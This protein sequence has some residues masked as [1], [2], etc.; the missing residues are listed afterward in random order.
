MQQGLSFWA[1]VLNTLYWHLVN[2]N[3]KEL[4]EAEIELE[5]VK[6]EKALH[7]FIVH[8]QDTMIPDMS[9]CKTNE[10]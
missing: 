1:F 10:F 3:I 9:S 4:E 6:N 8:P 2:H 5:I 7:S